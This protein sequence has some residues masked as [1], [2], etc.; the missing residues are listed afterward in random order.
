MELIK[1]SLLD[2][3]T[4]IVQPAHRIYW[5]Y[6]LTSLLIAAAVIAISAPAGRRSWRDIVRA[7]FPKSIYWHPSARVDY[8]YFVVNRILF[9]VL[10]LPVISLLG[11]MAFDGSGRL[12]AALFGPSDGVATHWRGGWIV[13]NTLASIVVID[14]AIFITH[15][16]AHR[17]PFLWEFHKV[18]HSAQVLTP[19]TVYRMHPV[20]DVLTMTLS[21]VLLGAT[22]A[23]F[24]HLGGTS[25]ETLQFLG[26]NAALF[27]FYLG[28]Y[29]LRHSHVWVSYGPWWSRLFISPA[30]HQ[31]HH[32]RDSRHFDRNFGFIFA[33]WDVLFGTLYVPRTREAIPFG[34]P[35]GED[36]RYQTL[37]RLYFLPFREAVRRAPNG[38]RASALL[39]TIL[40][41]A[42]MGS[43]LVHAARHVKGTQDQ[44]QGPGPTRPSPD[45]AYQL[46]AGGPPPA[47]HL[48]DLTWPEVHE[49]VA[50]GYDTVIVP[51]GGTE[52][53]GPH[54]V[55]GKHN[56]IVRHTA[57]STARQ[58]GRTLVAPV[59]AYVPQGSAQ[60]PTGHMR[61]AGTLS[62]PEDTFEAV[63]EHTVRSLHAHGFRLICLMGDS[64]GNMAAQ[65]RVA[66]RL[67]RELRGAGTVVVNLD[68][69]YRANGQVEWLL[70]DGETKMSIG[71]HAGIR[72]TSELLFLDP[73]GVRLDR[74]PSHDLEEADGA[75]GNASA[76]TSERGRALLGLKID[77]ATRQLT[78]AR[79][80]LPKAL[81][82]GP[83]SERTPLQ[84]NRIW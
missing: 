24:N 45:A 20:D 29:N 43:A 6:L 11:F 19:M 1:S 47:L 12:L 21:S 15:Y 4:S 50:T 69:Y 53:N 75:S 62:I 16:A 72:D 36:T 35:D 71:T 77:A 52:Q 33:F 9:G 56:R 40:C 27:L 7:C 54:L 10:F 37:A 28:G 14:F 17:V 5:L 68:K 66:R 23:T 13:L 55:L 57:E 8:V 39:L 42:I 67:S 70:R 84:A 60:P 83:A 81:P 3:L 26:L 82:S 76:G 58:V 49:L 41:L 80:A 31:I 34:L 44:A 73:T 78:A 22:Q 63:L 51:T 65:D 32:S 25:I 30:Q 64:G 79:E 74:L 59:M 18:H 2:P 48:E 38:V 61:F 46:P